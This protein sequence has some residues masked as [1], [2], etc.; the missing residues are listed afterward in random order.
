M[1]LRMH[2]FSVFEAWGCEGCGVLRCSWP[3]QID[4]DALVAD[5]EEKEEAQEQ[6][7]EQ[8]AAKCATLS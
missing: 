8:L 5:L 2:L 7:Q 3:K 4:E 1:L 6:E